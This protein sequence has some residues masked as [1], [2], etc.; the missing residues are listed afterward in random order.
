MYT[1][2]TVQTQTLYNI[3]RFNI[4]LI[5]KKKKKGP[6]LFTHLHGQFKF[7][8]SNIA[9]SNVVITLPSMLCLTTVL[10]D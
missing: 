9:T 1:V 6:C 3:P 2:E 7:S 5:V 10:L 4:S 8:S